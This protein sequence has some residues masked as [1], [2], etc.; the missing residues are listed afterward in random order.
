MASW[1]CFVSVSGGAA[2]SVTS[3]GGAALSVTSSGGAALSVTSSG[4]AALSSGGAAL[5][6]T[7]SGGAA[8]QSF[9]ND[10]IA[11]P[12]LTTNKEATAFKFAERRSSVSI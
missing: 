5:S 11:E 1:S 12:T 4:G 8:A 2:L 6:V 10:S 9:D 7:S 3:S